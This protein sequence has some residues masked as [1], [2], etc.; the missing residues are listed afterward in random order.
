VL[1]Q[2]IGSAV[3]ISDAVNGSIHLRDGDAFPFKQSYG[4]S[5]EIVRFL[6]AHPL[7]PGRETIVGRVALSGVVETIADV[8]ADTDFNLPVHQLG[9]VRSVLGAPLLREEEVQGVL[10]LCRPNP[11]EF[12]PSLIELAES[13]ADRAVIAI[14]NARLIEEVQ[15]KTRDLEESLAQQTATADVLKVISRSAFD[16]QAVLHT[17]VESAAKLCDADKATITREIDGVFY[18]AESYGFSEGFIA[19]LRNI[20]VLPERGTVSGR[21][22]LEGKAVQVDDVQADP[23]YT[24]ADLSKSEGFRTCLCVPMLRNGAPIG[25]LVLVRSQVR[26]FNEKQIELVQT[27]AD[28]AVIAIENARLFNEVQAKTRDLEA[29]LQQ[30]TATSDVLKV[31]SRSAFDLQAVLQTLVES[32]AKLCDAN[33]AVITREVDGVLYRAE[34]YGCSAEFMAEIRHLPILPGRGTVSGRV[35]LEGKAVQIQDVETD[36]E[37]A[38]KT[39]SRINEFHTCLGIPMLRNGVPIGVISLLRTEIRAFNDKQIELVQTFADQAVIAIENARLFDE[40]QAK[41]HDLEEALGQQTATADVLKVIS[42]SAF[43]LQTVLDTLVASAVSLCGAAGGI[44]FLRSG[45]TFQVKA[46]TDEVESRDAELLR[47]LRETPQ[48]P[49]RGTVGARVLLTGEVQNVADVQMDADY[50]PVLRSIITARALLGVPL[51]R[52]DEV[53]GAL[54]LRRTAPGAFSQRQIELVQTFADQAVIAIENARL[55]DEVQTKTRDL[56]EALGQQTATA[57][58]LKVISR[59]A[60]DLQAVLTTLADSA[61]ELCGTSF[62]TVHIRDGD[63]MRFQ[64]HSGLAPEAVEFLRAHPIA[65]G[66]ETN[67]GLVML[68]GRL[69]HRP[70]VFADPE[71]DFGAGPQIMNYRAVLAMPLLREGRVEGVFN[72]SRVEPG[73]F[74]QRQ[75]EMV[76]AFADQAVIAIENSRLFDEVQARTRQ[77]TASL[78]NLRKAQDR[79]IQ[80][81][82]LASLGQLTAGI[83]HEI[84]NPLNFV[85]NFSNLSREL[86]DELREQLAKGQFDAHARAEVDELVATIASNLDKVAQHGGRADS[87]VKNMLLHAREGSGERASVNVN[88]IVEEALNLAYHGARAE[89]PGFDVTI[90]RELD[91]DAGKADLYPQEITRVLLNLISNGFYATTKRQQV[92]SEPDYEPTLTASTRNLDDRVEIAI[93]DNGAGIPDDVKEKVFNPFFTTKPAGEGT[94]LG[95]SLSHDIVVKQHGGAIEVESAPGSTRFIIRLPRADPG[96]IH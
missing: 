21:A 20:P 24:F 70:D 8:L 63:V 67:T 33:M 76:Q 4:H 88:A 49:G 2:L 89:K 1:Q 58:V 43:D 19:Q 68:T 16:L 34:S 35:L 23:E 92:E 14:E 82:K 30:Q 32:A 74:T 53:I 10:V 6:A 73:P 60:F 22:L 59:S 29:S 13:F 79:L 50:D 11:G 15:A 95:L 38:F 55:F 7:R 96:G 65:P 40:V 52:G 18:R 28:Q 66:R 94:G 48:R 46:A 84:K 17:L 26:P 44:I 45:D 69:A 56:E 72:L 27:F 42:R 93:K 12:D 3:R 77:L 87:I 51:K 83:A 71:Y 36:P 75:I 61:R 31:I 37:Y 39:L 5:P 86:L 9:R 90:V 81:E 91:P 25:L 41:T 80:S 54:A 57:D 64:A 62:T 85:N 47:R 78:D